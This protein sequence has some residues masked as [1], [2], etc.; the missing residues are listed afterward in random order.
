MSKQN[1]RFTAAEDVSEFTVNAFGSDIEIIGGCETFAAEF[2]EGAFSAEEKK[3]KVYFKRKKTTLAALTR[4]KLKIEVPE[5]CVPEVKIVIKKSAVTFL[6]GI[7]GDCSVYGESSKILASGSAFNIVL[8]KGSELNAE[9]AST[10][11][12]NA[13][14]SNVKTGD[15]LGKNSF[16]SRM[17]INLKSGNAGLWETEFSMS[18]IS[19][20]RGNIQ[21][22]LTGGADDYKMSFTA[23]NGTCN[24]ESGGSGSKSL[25]FIASHGNIIVD[26]NKKKEEDGGNVND[27]V[28]ENIGGESGA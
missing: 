15:I 8:L 6:D 13:F 25:K 22:L 2:I 24:R 26:F 3:G 14:I 4:V 9:Y 5:S 21:A 28:T 11:V 7:Y 16:F 10:T 18:E 19:V 20:K 27:D 12:K 17:D 23:K 1:Y